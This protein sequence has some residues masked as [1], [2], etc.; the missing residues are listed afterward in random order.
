MGLTTTKAKYQPGSGSFATDL[1][2]FAARAPIPNTRDAL[3]TGYVSD[4]GRYMKIKFQGVGAKSASTFALSLGSR[5]KF[6]ACL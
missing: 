1:P 6:T 3:V 5:G 4:D 2:T